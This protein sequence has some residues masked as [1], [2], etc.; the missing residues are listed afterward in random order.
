MRISRYKVT[1]LNKFAYPPL[2][3]F[4]RVNCVGQE[5]KNITMYFD[6][7]ADKI[8]QLKIITDFPLPK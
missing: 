6:E 8:V 2:L 4:K 5:F 3:H 1:I 7:N